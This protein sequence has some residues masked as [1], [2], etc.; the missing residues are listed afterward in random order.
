MKILLTKDVPN[1]GRS[2]E[3][4]DVANGYARN[5]LIPRGLAVPASQGA[6]K[7]AEQAK[8]MAQG[9][10]ARVQAELEELANTVQNTELVFK[11]KVGEQHRLFGSVTAGDIAEELSRKVNHPIDKRDVELEEPIRHLGSYKV[12]IRLAPQLVPSVTVVVEAEAS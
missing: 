2:G 8:V 3:I 10:Q 1:V 7:Q 12:P 4:K 5:F 6:V 11:A 9:K